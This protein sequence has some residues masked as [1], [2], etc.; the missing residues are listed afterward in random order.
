MCFHPGFKA[1]VTGSWDKTI[2]LW[3]PQGAQDE[4]QLRPA[5]TIALPERLYSLDALP[6]SPLLVAAMANRLLATY[7]LRNPSQP[8]KTL[9][10]QLKF[11]SRRVALFKH[12]VGFALASVEGRC[13]LYEA[14]KE[15]PFSFKAAVDKRFAVN[16]LVTHASGAFATAH[17]D[18]RYAFWDAVSRKVLK[19]FSVPQGPITAM[20]I[21]QAWNKL[22][23][24]TGY[25]WV[26]GSAGAAAAPKPAVLLARISP[27]C[28]VAKK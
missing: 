11:Q 16:A 22:V 13:A 15:K 1:L 2:R 27:D 8:V 26:E 28:V 14:Q 10:S 20:A 25:D 23:L 24:A 12:T 17:S 21:N 6:R 19:T 4:A 9:H 3:S 18:G 5:L 7:D